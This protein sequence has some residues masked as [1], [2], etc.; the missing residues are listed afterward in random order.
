MNTNNFYEKAFEFIRDY[1][2]EVYDYNDL[3][4][5]TLLELGVIIYGCYF[6]QKFIYK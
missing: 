1:Y 4:G 5:P 3:F 6:I 2:N